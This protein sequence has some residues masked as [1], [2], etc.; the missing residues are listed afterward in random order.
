M[1][2]VEFLRGA[3]EVE[4]PDFEGLLE[5]FLALTDIF[6]AITAGTVWL[7]GSPLGRLCFAS[8]RTPDSDRGKRL[9]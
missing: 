6:T 3:P 8:H 1:L 4:D 2:E 7:R 9:E 5:D